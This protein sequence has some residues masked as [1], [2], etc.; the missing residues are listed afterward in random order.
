MDELSEEVRC[1]GYTVM[2]S[3]TAEKKSETT[4][5]Q[6]SQLFHENLMVPTGWEFEPVLHFKE[7]NKLS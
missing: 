1:K 4:T 6:K 7:D 3:E 5:A 2:K